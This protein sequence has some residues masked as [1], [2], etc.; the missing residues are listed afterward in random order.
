[1]PAREI[2]LIRHAESQWNAE[3]RWQGQADPPLSQRGT[4][5][6]DA[7]ARTWNMPGVTH[8]F[9]STLQRARSTAQPLSLEL[10]LRALEDPDLCELDVGSWEGKTRAEIHAEDPASLELF[11][12]GRQGWS[13]GESY[14]DHAHRADRFAQRLLLLPDDAVVVAVTHGGTLRAILLALLDMDH[15]LR[16]R[17]TGIGHVHR[18]SL[19]A[20]TNGYRLSSFNI[21]PPEEVLAGEPGASTGQSL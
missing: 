10:G 19:A 16:W 1:M 13:G 7:F 20:A 4:H 3:G 2:H 11:Q 15:D 8:L 18:T 21:P 6:A 17:F 12:L 14:D 5:Q 9:C